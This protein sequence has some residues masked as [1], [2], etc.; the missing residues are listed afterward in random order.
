MKNNI[1]EA[2]VFDDKSLV[3]IDTKTKGH[4]TLQ[5]ILTKRSIAW[6]STP[7]KTAT[8]VVCTREKCDK[9]YPSTT[10]YI[11]NPDWKN[12]NQSIQD[13][14]KN[15]SASCI[16]IDPVTG[17]NS[18]NRWYGSKFNRREFIGYTTSTGQKIN[19]FIINKSFNCFAGKKVYSYNEFKRCLENKNRVEIEDT[20]DS[21]ISLLTSKDEVNVKL[22]V[23][24]IEQYKMDKRWVPWLKLN[25][26]IKEVR[27]LLRKLGLSYKGTNNRRRY[28][29]NDIHYNL[30]M[31]DI[32][33]GYEID[34]IKALYEN[35]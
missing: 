11:I 22:A 31:L 4:K 32:P 12:I 6:T 23:I 27:L 1:N 28:I 35:E 14:F 3:F 7:H 17:Y 19:K 34:F 15:V 29:K 18:Y 13:K 9:F 33:K 10:K 25:Q 16:L 20:E 21:V 5:K 2:L 24:L 30:R 8:H 26:H